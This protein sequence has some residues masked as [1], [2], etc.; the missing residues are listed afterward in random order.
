MISDFTCKW[1]SAKQSVLSSSFSRSGDHGKNLRE[2]ATD[3]NRRLHY[4]DRKDA[5]RRK[6]ACGHHSR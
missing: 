6:L 2:H 4:S 5:K 1:R 3:M